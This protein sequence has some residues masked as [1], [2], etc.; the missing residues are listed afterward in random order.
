MDRRSV[1]K[2]A[3][4]AGVLAAGVAPV[5]H[6]QGAAIRWRLASSFPKALDT[7]Y[8]AAET[9]AKKVGEMSGGKFTITTLSNGNIGLLT[10]MAKHGG[11]PWDCVLSAEV[12]KAYKPDPAVYLGVA[13]VFDVAPAA[14]MLVAAHQDDLAAARACGL[15][16]AYIERPAEFGADRLK[17][18]SPDPA[19]T[20]HARDFM[21]LAD[22]LCA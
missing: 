5:V 9:F 15:Q 17:D 12:F 1:I 8:G 4:I 19:N 21:D 16:T 2:N 3:G 20:L 10:H 7:I 11:L 22:R 6:A 13:R 14:V 18:V